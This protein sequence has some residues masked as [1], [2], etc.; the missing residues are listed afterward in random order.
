M[1]FTFVR[2]TTFAIVPADLQSAGIEYKEFSPELSDYFLFCHYIVVLNLLK[3]LF[4]LPC[5]CLYS[6]FIFKKS[7]R[8]DMASASIFQWLLSR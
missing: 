4:L 2:C 6:K 5:A 8:F 3:H 7:M 1:L